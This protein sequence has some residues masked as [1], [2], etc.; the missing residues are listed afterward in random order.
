MS[1]PLAWL[2]LLFSSVLETCWA[3]LT[4]YTDGFTKAVP[5]IAC[6]A[7]AGFNIFLLAIVFKHLPV[8]VAYS[9]WVGI[10]VIGTACA[11]LYLFREPVSMVQ[12]AFMGLILIGIIGV[13]LG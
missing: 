7:L 5:T 4:K 11:S 1:L 3:I 9:V 2:L 13:K 8:A 6:L 10:S 12:L